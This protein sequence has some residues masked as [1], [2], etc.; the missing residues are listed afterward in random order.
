MII[1]EI[2]L[3]KPV[4]RELKHIMKSDYLITKDIVPMKDGFNDYLFKK[5]REIKESYESTDKNL[6]AKKR[7]EIKT[8]VE[9]LKEDIHR[10]K[11][12]LIA[13]RRDAEVMKELIK[14]L[15][16]ENAQLSSKVRKLRGEGK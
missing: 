16:K 1:A 8:R 15:E 11:R 3:R 10:M 6:L 2:K 5:L 12:I 4:D 9:K 7:D 14:K 13:S